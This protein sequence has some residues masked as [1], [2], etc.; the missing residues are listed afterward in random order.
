MPQQRSEQP[1]TILPPRRF[2]SLSRCIAGSGSAVFILDSCRQLSLLRLF[3]CLPP[4]MISAPK[5]WANKRTEISAYRLLANH[6]LRTIC[7]VGGL[8]GRLELGFLSGRHFC[9]YA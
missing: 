4:S 9:C 3:F 2:I 7:G 5:N 6:G 8:H 1:H